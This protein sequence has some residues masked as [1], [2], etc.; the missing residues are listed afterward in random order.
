MSDTELVAVFYNVKP[1]KHIQVNSEHIKM[2]ASLRKNGQKIVCCQEDIFGKYLVTF[3]V[4]DH[5]CPLQMVYNMDFGFGVCLRRAF[6][7]SFLPTH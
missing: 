6:W 7:F 1:R 4:V 2:T 3:V 5:I